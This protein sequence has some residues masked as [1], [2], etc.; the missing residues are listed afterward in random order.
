MCAKLPPSVFWRWQRYDFDLSL[1]SLSND[2]PL[3]LYL[4]PCAKSMSFGEYSKVDT[5]L[6]CAASSL[7]AKWPNSH[8]A[9]ALC[10]LPLCSRTPHIENSGRRRY[11]DRDSM[12]RTIQIV[13]LENLEY[14]Q[15]WTN[16]RQHR[17]V[18]ISNLNDSNEILSSLFLHSYDPELNHLRQH[19]ADRFLSTCFSIQRCYIRDM[20]RKLWMLTR[21]EFPKQAGQDHSHHQRRLS[22]EKRHFFYCK[23]TSVS[24][25]GRKFAV[26]CDDWMSQDILAQVPKENTLKHGLL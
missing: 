16:I 4:A 9:T 3:F 20:D 12:P 13:A 11:S 7:V 15:C 17:L 8:F 2:G 14:Y 10:C 25:T 18:S 5:G 26:S 1:S 6:H 24:A 19:I 22:L 21:G 23:E